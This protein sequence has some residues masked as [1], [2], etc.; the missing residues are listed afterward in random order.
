[1]A[2]I[3][4]ELDTPID[5]PAIVTVHYF[6][7]TKDFIFS[8]ESH[9]FW[10]FVYVD[11][12]DVTIITRDCERVL[13]SGEIVFHKPNEWH[14][15]R[16]NGKIAPNVVIMSFYMNSPFSSFFENAVLPAG[17]FQKILLS[18]IIDESVDAFSS[19]LDNPYTEQLIKK[20]GSSCSQQFIK[21]YLTEFLLLFLHNNTHG[22]TSHIHYTADNT[23][24]AAAVDFMTEN[25]SRKLY[26]SDIAEALNL[27]SA[28]LKKLFREN[29]ACGVMDY[30]G[31]MKI[32]KAKEY[33][34]ERN[35]NLSVISALLGY[36]TPF[37]FSAC[38]KKYTDMSPSEY[39]RSVTSRLNSG[40]S[41]SKL[42]KM[43]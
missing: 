34:R 41:S 25:L 28:S 22:G 31:K 14:N 38:F 2:Y 13:H 9:D 30:F 1:M 32:E 5:I 26:I 17:N 43:Q 23:T 35:H 42:E 8:G 15:I 40:I 19:P 12:G 20:S 4:T 6:E 16:A 36:S 24:F 11:K 39:A 3:K 29:A 33:I 21:L 27:S 37:Y 10:E 18:K 7:Y